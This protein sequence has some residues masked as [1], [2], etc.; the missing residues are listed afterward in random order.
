MFW[1]RRRAYR[2]FLVNKGDGDDYDYFNEERKTRVLSIMFPMNFPDV[3]LATKNDAN[4]SGS[5]TSIKNES[6]EILK[7]GVLPIS[8]QI[9]VNL[10]GDKSD[11]VSVRSLTCSFFHTTQGFIKQLFRP[12][13]RALANDAANVSSITARFSEWRD[14][15]SL[16]CPGGY[17][18]GYIEYLRATKDVNIGGEGKQLQEILLRLSSNRILQGFTSGGKNGK[19]IDFFDKRPQVRKAWIMILDLARSIMTAA[20]ERNFDEFKNIAPRL[21]WNLALFGQLLSLVSGPAAIKPH[22]IN[23]CHIWI[24]HIHDALELGITLFNFCDELVIEMYHQRLRVFATRNMGR[25]TSAG[26]IPY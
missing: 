23:L 15:L 20:G 19:T 12:L 1:S 26:K 6:S 9:K 11:K 22:T 14:H 7:C 13:A 5:V 25:Y 18:I 10:Y 2:T 8:G 3:E 16:T 21:Q 24:S 17:T 4:D